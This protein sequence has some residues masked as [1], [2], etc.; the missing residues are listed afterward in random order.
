MVPIFPWGGDFKAWAML[1]EVWALQMTVHHE[2]NIIKATS[3]VIH[4]DYTWTQNLGSLSYKPLKDILFDAYSSKQR[5]GW[6]ASPTHLPG[7][8]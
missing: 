1:L 4:S 7:M 3:L 5:G 6:M 8:Q 2:W